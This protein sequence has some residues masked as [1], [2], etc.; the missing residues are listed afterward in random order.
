MDPIG[1]N[2]LF[3]IT[4]RSLYENCFTSKLIED[5]SENGINDQ[6]RIGR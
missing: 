3:N 4:G 5:R 6:E 2:Y 1:S